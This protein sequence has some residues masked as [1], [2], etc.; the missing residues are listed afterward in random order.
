L[1][2]WDELCRADAVLVAP[3]AHKLVLVFVYVGK[4]GAA[5]VFATARD[6]DRFSQ[7]AAAYQAHQLFGRVPV[8]SFLRISCLIIAS[9]RTR[10]RRFVHLPSHAICRKHGAGDI[11]IRD[12]DELAARDTRGTLDF[13]GIVSRVAVCRAVAD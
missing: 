13:E 4:A 5:K 9:I 1:R 2:I 6:N 3:R 10:E 7:K 12:G 11:L 8:G